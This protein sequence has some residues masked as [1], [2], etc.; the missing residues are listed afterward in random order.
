MGTD[1]LREDGGAVGHYVGFPA[2]GNRPATVILEYRPQADGTGALSGDRGVVQRD[3]GSFN[4]L[5][6]T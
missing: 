2:A 3:R 1:A 5:V 6:V 4:R